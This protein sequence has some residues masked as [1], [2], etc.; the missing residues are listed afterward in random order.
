M[1]EFDIMRAAKRTTY[2]KYCE[3]MDNDLNGIDVRLNVE[4]NGGGQGPLGHSRTSPKE[5][6]RD[7][8]SRRAARAEQVSQHLDS[9]ERMI[10]ASQG[11]VDRLSEEQAKVFGFLQRESSSLRDEIEALR[12]R[13]QS[14]GMHVRASTVPCIP[15]GAVVIGKVTMGT[16][17]ER[18]GVEKA[19]REGHC[20][21]SHS[22][23]GLMPAFGK[24]TSLTARSCASEE[25]TSTGTALTDFCHDGHAHASPS[26]GVSSSFHVLER[27][28][29]EQMV[30]TQTGSGTPPA[31]TPLN[32]HRTPNGSRV[33]RGS[34]PSK[35]VDAS[36]KKIKERARLSG[37]KQELLEELQRSDH[38]PE[39]EEGHHSKNRFC[40]HKAM[41]YSDA[42][43]RH[44]FVDRDEMKE[45]MRD[46]LLEKEYSV[47][48]YYKRSGIWQKIARS[49]VFENMTLLVIALNAVWIAADVDFNEAD[50]LLEAEALFQFMDNFFCF[51]FL[52]EW[53]VRFMAFEHKH[54]GLGDSWFVFDGLLM[55]MSVVDTW[56]MALGV[57]FL[58]A[59]MTDSGWMS[60]AVIFKLLRLVR[61]TRLARMAKL[62]RVMPELMIMIKGMACAMRSVFFTLCLLML[63][64]YVFAITF[65]QLM[66]PRGA[67][68]P[69]SPGFDSDWFATVPRAMMTLLLGGTMPDEAALILPVGAEHPCSYLLIMLFILLAGLTVMNM[70]VGVLCEVVS[71]VSSVERETLLVSF[72]QSQLEELLEE[73]GADADKNTKL[74]RTEFLNLLSHPLAARALRD[75]GVDVIG[76]VD[77]TDHIFENGREL[78]FPEFMK[79]VLDLRGSN[80]ATV[81]DIIEL[82]KLVITEIRRLVDDPEGEHGSIRAGVFPGS[83]VFPTSS[84]PAA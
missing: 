70:L 60:N 16:V 77:F 26:N 31:P 38:S 40:H 17:M 72:V 81:K 79:L 19:S 84:L 6:D 75:V 54:N 51:Y 3:A 12:H 42:S 83:E 13:L 56:F 50:V 37:F 46:S 29:E 67:M 36:R 8:E 63:I 76:L 66:G 43:R 53:F 65:V 27:W 48:N 28:K 71:V 59:S 52:F 49:A 15:P 1:D 82:R 55:V 34:I 47:H 62:F 10:V 18:K 9:V 5:K 74:S 57:L 58:K 80:S 39:E 23:S 21:L 4:H 20:G 32:G 22:S 78:T 61:I 25:L 2:R 14:S 11:H 30:P 69:L 24:T 33:A 7:K 45:K 41:E 68:Q 64:V 44:V 73:A 35:D